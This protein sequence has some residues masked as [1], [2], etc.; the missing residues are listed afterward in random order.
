MH[1]IEETE[2]K[3]RLFESRQS[4]EKNM[5]KCRDNEESLQEL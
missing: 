4:K 2:I 3:K 1:Q 5:R